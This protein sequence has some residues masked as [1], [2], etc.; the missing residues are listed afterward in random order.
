MPEKERIIFTH[1][2]SVKIFFNIFQALPL[3]PDV[4]AYHCKG[5]YPSPLPGTTHMNSK[6]SSPL[7]LKQWGWLS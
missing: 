1:L 4:A 5:T 6:D 2:F 7:F 3:D